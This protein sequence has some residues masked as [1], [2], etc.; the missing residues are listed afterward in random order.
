MQFLR[1]IHTIY[2]ILVYAILFLLFFPFF[3]LISFNTK[4]HKW[5]YRIDHLWAVLYFPLIFF[6]TEIQYEGKKTGREP[7][8]YC[9]N[10]FSTIDIPSLALL[11]KQACYV[12]KASIKKVP[13]FGYMFKTLHITVDR[14]SLKDRG[15]AFQNYAKA[16][17]Q[18]KSLFIYPEGGISSRHI[19]KQAN[20]KDGAFRVAIEQNVP[21]VPITIPFN[22][23]VLP[24]GEWIIKKYFVK[25]VVHE[26]ID[27][28]QLTLKDVPAL[29]EKV[30][31][32]IQNQID[33]ENNIVTEEQLVN[34]T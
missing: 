24:D 2:A 16:I 34:A 14:N 1:I 26:P 5:A 10:H 7:V 19:P 31:H 13:L 33:Y 9:A 22:W 27:T 3:L 30:Y 21:I 4:W 23:G 11:P 25:L 8:I 29:K 15:R 17:N 28:S 6:K 18:G 20:Y 32:I 12:G